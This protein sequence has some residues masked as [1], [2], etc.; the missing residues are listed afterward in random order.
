MKGELKPESTENQ[1]IQIDLSHALW[2]RIKFIRGLYQILQNPN[3]HISFVSF[4]C[5]FKI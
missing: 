2:M 1:Q 4:F 5:Q 3:E